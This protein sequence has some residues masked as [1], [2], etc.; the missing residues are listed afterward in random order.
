MIIIT[1]GV[2]GRP[3]QNMLQWHIDY[4]ELKLLEKQPVKRNDINKEGK[5]EKDTSFPPESRN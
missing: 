4:L 5:K 1:V 3:P 2:Q